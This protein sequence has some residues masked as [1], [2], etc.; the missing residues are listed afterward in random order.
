MAIVECIEEI[1]EG[2]EDAN[3]YDIVKEEE[4]C[5]NVSTE[6]EGFQFLQIEVEVFHRRLLEV[7]T[8]NY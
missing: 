3:F 2:V 6:N 5:I 1:Y 4:E 8:Y 7:S